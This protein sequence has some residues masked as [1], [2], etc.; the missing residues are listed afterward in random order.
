MK[1][2]WL[3]FCL[4]CLLITPLQPFFAALDSRDGEMLELTKEEKAKL[5]ER[6]EHLENQVL[7]LVF[8]AVGIIQERTTTA[9][10]MG[11]LKYH[12]F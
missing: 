8:S 7:S 9:K 10:N 6:M 12:Q 1:D 11:I 4:L 5:T 2:V 3:F